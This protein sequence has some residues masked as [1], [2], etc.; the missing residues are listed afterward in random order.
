[1]I[2][3]A[4][5]PSKRRH[6]PSPYTAR[7]DASTIRRGRVSRLARASS[8]EHARRT[9]NVR[10]GVAAG[11][12]QRLAGSRFG[13]QVHDHLRPV[14]SDR[15]EDIDPRRGLAHIA[16]DQLNTRGEVCGPPAIRVDLGVE[17]V[18]GDHAV[19]GVEQAGAIAQAMNPAPPVTTTVDV[20]MNS[21][22][23]WRASTAQAPMVR[24]YGAQRGAMIRRQR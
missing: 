10:A 13:G 7:D 9:Q 18:H 23:Q 2:S 6:A 20:L 4:S 24:N 16:D 22:R 5:S 12:G 8:I 3:L 11:F 19:E 1:M 15:G 21:P 14:L 17:A